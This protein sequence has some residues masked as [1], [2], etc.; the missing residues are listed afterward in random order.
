MGSPISRPHKILGIGL[1]HAKHV[2]ESGTAVP[3]EPVVFAKATSSLSGPYDDILLPPGADKVDWEVELGVVVGATARY[4]SDEAAVAGVIAGYLVA[5][6]VSEREYQLE[7]GGQWIKGKSADTFCPVGPW[8]VTHPMS[9]VASPTWS[10]PA[11][12]TARR[13]SRVLRPP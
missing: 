9:S 1:N 8:L 12:S 6:D 4:L 2:E 7:R 13:G 10:S 3:N 11:A 5:H